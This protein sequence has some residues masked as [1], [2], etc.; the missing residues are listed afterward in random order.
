MT[1]QTKAQRLAKMIERYNAGV[2]SQAIVEN[3]ASAADELRRLDALKAEL[4]EALN[5]LVKRDEADGVVYTGDHPITQAKAAL[6][7]AK[8]QT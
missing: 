7:K 2:H 5:R 1:E 4:V 3:Y 6:A 8:A